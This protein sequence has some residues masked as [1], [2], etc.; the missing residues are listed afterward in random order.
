TV[1]ATAMN[2]V[3]RVPHTRRGAR[4]RVAAASSPAAPAHRATAVAA[5]TSWGDSAKHRVMLEPKNND[6]A[7]PDHSRSPGP[8]S[9]RPSAIVREPT[10]EK[11]APNRSQPGTWS[12]GAVPTG[13][14][15]STGETRYTCRAATAEA[16][17]PV[18]TAATTA[19][20]MPATGKM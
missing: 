6:S 2:T 4:S 18:A 1:T 3:I 17:T 8:S 14:S 12:D 19:T 20:G 11:P 7:I 5:R 10:A 15:A 9:N 16:V 13:A